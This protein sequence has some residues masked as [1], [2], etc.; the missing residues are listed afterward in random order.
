MDSQRK[1]EQ[2]RRREG[3]DTG[4][5]AHRSA[6]ISQQ[7]SGSSR[8]MK[9]PNSSSSRS[10]KADDL[11]AQFRAQAQ[12]KPGP[13]PKPTATVRE[14]RI[15]ELSGTNLTVVIPRPRKEVTAPKSSPSNGITE[16]AAKAKRSHSK[17]PSV[18]AV[19]LAAANPTSTAV[20]SASK[21]ASGSEKVETAA[22]ALDATLESEQTRRLKKEES[23]RKKVHARVES[24]LASALAPVDPQHAFE[25][26]TSKSEQQPEPAPPSKK[27]IH[28]SGAPVV[29]LSFASLSS[30]P[31]TAATAP[32]PGGAAIPSA[33]HHRSSSFPASAAVVPPTVSDLSASLSAARRQRPK[34]SRRTELDDEDD[35]SYSIVERRAAA[36]RWLLRTLDRREEPLYCPSWFTAVDTEAMLHLS[37]VRQHYLALVHTFS[38]RE[39]ALSFV[40]ELKDA[41]MEEKAKAKTRSKLNMMRFLQGKPLIQQPIIQRPQTEEKA[42]GSSDKSSKSTALP[43]ANGPIVSQRLRARQGSQQT[44]H[45]TQAPIAPATVPAP[46]SSHSSGRSSQAPLL[47]S[48]VAI[49]G[50]VTDS[51]PLKNAVSLPADHI[52][53]PA[54]AHVATPGN[55]TIEGMSPI[56]SQSDETTAT[57]SSLVSSMSQAIKAAS[58]VSP[59][60]STLNDSSTG[61]RFFAQRQHQLKEQQQQQQLSDFESSITSTPDR[62]VLMRGTPAKQQLTDTYST[63]KSLVGSAPSPPTTLSPSDYL[64]QLPDYQMHLMLSRFHVLLDQFPLL[65]KHSPTDPAGPPDAFVPPPKLAHVKLVNGQ[66]FWNWKPHRKLSQ[67]LNS[68][69]SMRLVDVVDVRNGLSPNVTQRQVI[70]TAVPNASGAIP[71][72]TSLDDFCFHILARV[73]H[74]AVSPRRGGSMCCTI[75]S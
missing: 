7:S 13:V 14:E 74:D 5:N 39:Q 51:A 28:S 1:L 17:E 8:I 4:I 22:S 56:R 3:D 70:P 36:I 50:G 23:R 58:T 32:A 42:N 46:I 26:A 11:V 49:S 61:L 64:A 9:R 73:P 15:K 59:A 65:I 10:R 45:A 52:A 35:P 19:N 43:T 21:R 25:R 31:S 20:A 40:D 68:S 44:T 18:A 27:E 57:N 38:L 12:G 53:A 75:A 67:N 54:P 69:K 63:A 16:A 6:R 33:I 24:D 47:P 62:S 60:P 71:E 34:T 37:D 66:L 29:T 55:T 41:W 30:K 48:S 2:T 72:A